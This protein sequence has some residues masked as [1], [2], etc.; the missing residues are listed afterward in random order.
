MD[1]SRIP[2]PTAEDYA[3]LERYKKEYE[4]LIQMLRDYY[5]PNR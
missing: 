2:N 5:G 1:I 4:I 3:R